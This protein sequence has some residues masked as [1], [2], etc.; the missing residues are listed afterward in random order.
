MHCAGSRTRPLPSATPR[1]PWADC[2]RASSS[3]RCGAPCRCRM[4][5]AG[6]II[7]AMRIGA[8]STFRST[9]E[10]TWSTSRSRH[11][12]P[13]AVRISGISSGLP[14]TVPVAAE[15][16]PDRLQSWAGKARFREPD[17]C[18]S[19]EQPLEQHLRMRRRRRRSG[20]DCTRPAA[21]QLC[22]FASAI[23][24]AASGR[25]FRT[26]RHVSRP[27]S[28]AAGVWNT[29]FRRSWSSRHSA[30]RST[31]ASPERPHASS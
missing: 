23:H 16:A 24:H 6:Y 2:W 30:R 10:A 12:P 25:M 9:G 13:Q 3:A 17:A 28:K 18:P 26:A 21:R 7:G 11:R 31:S 20:R 15:R 29:R 8:R 27:L 19:R 14:P 22:Q 5:T 1:R 4:P